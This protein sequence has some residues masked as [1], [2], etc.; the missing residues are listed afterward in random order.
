MMGCRIPD[1][2]RHLAA[3]TRSAAAHNAAVH[4][5]A[6]RCA[7]V[8]CAAVRCAAVRCAAVRCA[9]VRCAAVHS[10]APRSAGVRNAGVRNAAVRNVGV[11]R[12]IMAVAAVALVSGAGACGRA[13]GAELPFTSHPIVVPSAPGGLGDIL[14]REVGDR[15]ATALRTPVIID[16]K[17]GGAG[18]VGNEAAARAA[19]DGYTLLLATSATYITASQAIGKLNY[20]PLRDFVPVFNIAYATSVIVVNPTLPVT[21]LAELID[22]A[23]AR[24][25]RLNYASS[26]VG[27]ANHLD[28]EV[29]ASL[30]GIQLLHVPYRGT[31]DGYRALLA[32]EVQIMFGAVTSALPFITAGR[33]RPLAVLVDKRSPLLPD[34]PTLAQAGLGKVDVRK[35]LGLVAPAGTQ[36]E[37]VGQLNRT[38]ER[39]LHGPGMR[40]WLDSQGLEVAGGSPQQFDRELR[41][42]YVK[43]GEVVRRLH[44]RSE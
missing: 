44:I 4:S 13:V 31:A 29:F 14:A 28:T 9:A 10:A 23:K 24:P 7:A 11:R 43:W 19:P 2:A 20:D 36:P 22:Y 21:T 8:R 34:V 12:V 37:I 26:G 33:I 3:V 42:D 5:A 6:V 38:L 16:N 27:S 18:V 25:G 41:A 1:I 30:A 32:N 35:W 15:L 17:P 40:A 39:I